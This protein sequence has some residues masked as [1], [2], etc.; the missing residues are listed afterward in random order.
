MDLVSVNYTNVYVLAVCM[1]MPI[2][3]S[4]MCG[5]PGKFFQYYKQHGTLEDE[6]LSRGQNL[7]KSER[8]RLLKSSHTLLR[9]LV[10][11][12]NDNADKIN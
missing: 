7:Q 11:L 3:L 12:T 8:S 10:S 1:I 5:W 9:N 6:E 4:P 2:S